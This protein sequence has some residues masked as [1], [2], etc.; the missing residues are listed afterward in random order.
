MVTVTA[1][2]IFRLLSKVDYLHELGVGAIW[3]TPFYPSP[4]VDN[5][6]DISDYCAVDARFGTL[7]DFRKVVARCHACGIRVIIDL[8]INHVSS[9]H[10]WFRDAWNNPASRYRDYFLF[11]KQPNNWQSFFSGSARTAEPDT[12]EFTITSLPRAGRSQ[13]GE[14]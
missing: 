1:W 3:I 10:P 7:E 14:P 2:A 8:V 12:G 13:L 5:G 6:Y 9:A 4:L 11:S